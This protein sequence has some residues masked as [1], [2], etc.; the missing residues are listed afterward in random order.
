MARS[1]ETTFVRATFST[2]EG[3]LVAS[4]A[5]RACS[6]R[7]FLGEGVSV[8]VFLLPS[9]RRHRSRI[10]ACRLRAK[11]AERIRAPRR[12]RESY[13]HSSHCAVTDCIAQSGDDRNLLHPGRRS[14]PDWPHQVR[15]VARLRALRT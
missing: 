1:Q 3:G 14:A 2:S 10:D 9:P 7:A 13:T 5:F 8:F 11:R 12:L 15:S 6:L 4:C